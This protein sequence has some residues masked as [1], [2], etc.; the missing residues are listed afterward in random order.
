MK[1][2]ILADKNNADLISNYELSVIVAD[3]IKF[4]DVGIL[5]QKAYNSA[6]SKFISFIRE[7]NLPINESTLIKFREYAKI[8]FS[9]A[10]ARLYFQISRKFCQWTCKKMNVADFTAGVKGVKVDSSIHSRDALPLEDC[11]AVINNVKGT[12]FVAIRNKTIL[13]LMVECGL[14]RCEINR[15]DCGDIE[16]R[17]GKYFL[18]IWGKCRAGK[19]DFVQLPKSAKKILDEYL[20]LRGECSEN[21]PLFVSNSN[22]SKGRRLDVQSIS[23]LTKKALREGGFD[24]KRLT[25][26]SLRH[27]FASGAISAG[28]DIRDIQKIL[29]H[30]SVTTSEI[31]IADEK[32]YSN[33]ATEIVANKLE[34]F[35]KG[36]KNRGQ[37]K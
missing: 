8:N 27:S 4:C 37:K 17:R 16:L 32:F 29:R 3:W 19:N 22:N 11:A 35:L 34:K 1:N 28:V 7:N 15:L 26:H 20:K 31:Y 6:A 9:V 13:L 24:S 10:T 23:K 30:K 36:G 14:R 33:N 12:D 5:T 18:R 25:C 2:L 21:S